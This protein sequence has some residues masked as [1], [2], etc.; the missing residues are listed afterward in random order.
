MYSTYFKTIFIVCISLCTTKWYKRR[1]KVI[2]FCGD[3]LQDIFTLILTDNG[4]S[5]DGNLKY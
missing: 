3:V 5:N 1:W 2:Q 4:C